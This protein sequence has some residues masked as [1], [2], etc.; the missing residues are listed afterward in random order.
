MSTTGGS[1]EIISAMPSDDSEQINLL[2]GCKE[3]AFLQLELLFQNLMLLVLGLHRKKSFWTR[4]QAMPRKINAGFPPRIIS[5]T[6]EQAP[7]TSCRDRYVC[8]EQL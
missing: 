2:R 1:K 7:Y 5:Y 6:E 8:K 4:W 3:T